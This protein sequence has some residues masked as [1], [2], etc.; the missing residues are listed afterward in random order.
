M[1]TSFHQDH[2]GIFFNA[3]ANGNQCN[4]PPNQILIGL[5]VFLTIF[6][7]APVWQ[8]I[9]TEAIQPYLAVEEITSEV[10][11]ERYLAPIRNLAFK[12]TRRKIRALFVELADLPAPATRM[13]YLP[14]SYHLLL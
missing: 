5:T 10:M 11:Y 7:M 13:R 1:L 4:M 3:F 14:M 9:N 2:S 8:E 12:Q 6:T